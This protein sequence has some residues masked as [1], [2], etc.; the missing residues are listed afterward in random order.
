MFFFSRKKLN[1][2]SLVTKGKVQTPDRQKYAYGFCDRTENGGHSGGGTT[3]RI[4]SDL[5]FVV[6]VLSNSEHPRRRLSLLNSF[7]IKIEK[8][9]ISCDKA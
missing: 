4:C 1:L 8:W 2:V 3:L 7:L 9:D 5:R 6:I